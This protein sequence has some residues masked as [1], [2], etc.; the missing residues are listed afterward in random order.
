MSNNN[1]PKSPNLEAIRE[2]LKALPLEDRLSLL[3]SELADSGLTVVFGGNSRTSA[4]ICVNIYSSKDLEVDQLL[5]TL[6]DWVKNK[7]K[8]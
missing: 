2:A 3:Q 6:G 8:H 4:Q 5:H 7:S 1:I